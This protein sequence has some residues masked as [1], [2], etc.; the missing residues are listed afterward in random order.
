[1]MTIITIEERM[2]RKTKM[3]L[4][5]SQRVCSCPTQTTVGGGLPETKEIR[6]YSTQHGPNGNTEVS[7]WRILVI[8]L[9]G[10]FQVVV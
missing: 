10:F 7:N 2:V 8:C 5:K 4:I 3:D 6:Q 9:T 1:M